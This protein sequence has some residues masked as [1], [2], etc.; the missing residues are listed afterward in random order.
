M[1]LHFEGIL[2]GSSSGGGGDTPS[3]SSSLYELKKY[4]QGLIVDDWCNINSKKELAK[5]TIPTVYADLL[6]KYQNVDTESTGVTAK[7]SSYNPTFYMNGYYYYATRT[8]NSSTSRNFQIYRSAN[9]DLSDAELVYETGTISGGNIMP[10]LLKGEDVIIFIHGNNVSGWVPEFKMFDLDFNLL[11]SYTQTGDIANLMSQ[12][13]RGYFKFYKNK[14]YFWSKQSPCCYDYVNNVITNF[15]TFGNNERM[16]SDLIIIDDYL[17]FTKGYNTLNRINVNTGVA[18]SV[19]LSGMN[20]EASAFFVYNG[21][22]K[23]LDKNYVLTINTENFTVTSVATSTFLPNISLGPVAFVKKIGDTYYFWINKK[24]YTTTDWQNFSL[25]MENVELFTSNIGQYTT[26]GYYYSHIGFYITDDQSIILL[27]EYNGPDS[28]WGS[29]NGYYYYSGTVKKE[30]TDD[31]TIDG[32]T[33]SIKYFKNAGWKI[34][35]PDTTNDANLETVYTSLGYLPYWRID[36]T[37]ENLTLI[38]TNKA[39]TYMYVGDGYKDS[40]TPTGEWE[41]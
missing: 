5:A 9:I 39:F 34:C 26:Y 35:V 12:E 4:P 37:G 30:Y 27:S 6:E 11:H 14:L 7:T 17:Y 8:G 13:Y 16:Y 10:I 24:I 1:T 15:G 22:L 20:P 36:V 19:S 23:L 18:E 40:T 21:E 2:K 3:A 29:S 33:V 28:I 32:N 41:G 31:Y 25:L 38:R